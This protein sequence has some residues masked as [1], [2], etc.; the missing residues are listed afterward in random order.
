MDSLPQE[1][2]MS[3]AELRTFRGGVSRWLNEREKIDRWC[4]NYQ[5]KFFCR[6]GSDSIEKIEFVVWPDTIEIGRSV[7]YRMVV[8]T[9]YPNEILRVYPIGWHFQK[10]GNEF[11]H[12]YTDSDD[13]EHIC[14]MRK[15]E[16]SRKGTIAGTMV[17]A[18]KWHHKYEIYLET[19]K[20][21][22]AGRDH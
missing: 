11:N 3:M 7:R 19:G 6:P 2:L 12:V 10:V 15:S 4:S 22:G 17:L 8:V 14:M 9:D 21:P 18:A 13:I 5:A 16:W 1:L 20:W